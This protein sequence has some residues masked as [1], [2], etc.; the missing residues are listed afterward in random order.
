M[1]RASTEA[2]Y[3][4]TGR[5]D[6]MESN[7]KRKQKKERKKFNTALEYRINNLKKISKEKQNGRHTSTIQK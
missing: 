7:R 4:L 3:Y 2:L 1:K 5:F 6:S